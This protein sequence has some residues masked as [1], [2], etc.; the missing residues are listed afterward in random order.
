MI[1]IFMSHFSLQKKRIF[2][3]FRRTDGR[4]RRARNASLAREEEREK[5]TACKH[6]IVQ[7]GQ[8]FKYEPGYLIGYFASRDLECFSKT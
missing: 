7:A 3:Y 1:D 6:T 2:A 5:F 4:A 8:G